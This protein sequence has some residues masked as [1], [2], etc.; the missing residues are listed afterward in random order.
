[1]LVGLLLATA[2][3]GAAEETLSPG[4]GVTAVAA[5]ETEEETVAADE[6]EPA[7]AESEDAGAES[8][9]TEAADAEQAG[10]EAATTS[11]AASP[12]DFSAVDAAIGAFVEDRALNGAG[13]IV[14]HRDLGVIHHE[15][16]GVFDEDRI[17]LLASSSKMV[18]AGVLLHLD[19]QGILD[20]DAPIADIAEWGSGNPEITPA[21]LL[22][23]S[24]GLVGLLP[25][26]LYAPYLCQWISGTTLQDCG[27]TIMTAAGD[28][29]DIVPPDTEFRYGGAQWQVAGAVAEVAS[30]KTWYE[31]ID[32]IYVQ[33][34]GLEVFGYNNHFDQ[35]AGAGFTHPP[36]FASNPG[37][38]VQSA[39]PNMEGGAYSNTTDYAQLLLMHLRGGVCGDTQ[40]LSPEAL[41]RM[42]GDRI[43][44]VYGG[45]AWGADQ[46]YGM[47]W[48]VYRDSGYLQDGGAY[49]SVPWLDLDEGYGAFLLTESDSGTAGELVDSIRQ[50]VDD[51]VAAGLA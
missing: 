35:I 20:V 6:S 47:G 24:S 28:D 42:H 18:T 4:G 27:A 43:G 40:V 17:S 37:Q 51:A 26:L 45:D 2:C 8:D 46:G 9:E 49:G 33:P 13:F 31:L 41:A 16:W 48:W 30:G 7:G 32:E 21:Q 12:F 50:L 14:V 10:D 15:H 23:N 29:A 44:E 19:D 36:A 34:C 11:D 38:L 1:L 3:S 39:N 22:S 25:D 5:D